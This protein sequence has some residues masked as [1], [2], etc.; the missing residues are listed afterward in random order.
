MLQTDAPIAKDNL[1]EAE[2]WLAEQF[3]LQGSLE[4]LPGEHDRNF[5]VTASDGGRYLF[6]VHP[7]A[8]DDARIDLQAAVLRHLEQHAPELPLPRLFLGRDGRPLATVPDAEGRARRLR[9]TTWLDGTVWVDAPRRGTGA[10]TRRPRDG[11][12]ARS[13]TGPQSRRRRRR[14]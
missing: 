5:K 10:V 2:R 12:C 3:A 14:R 13:S 8:P 6:K 9:L 1:Q 11:T 7:A 4:P